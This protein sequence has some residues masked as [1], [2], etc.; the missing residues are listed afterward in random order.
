MLEDLLGHV[1]IDRVDEHRAGGGERPEVA[2]SRAG[3]CRAWNL[4]DG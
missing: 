3:R 2:V 1:P 4:P